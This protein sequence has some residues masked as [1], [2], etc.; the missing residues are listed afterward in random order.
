MNQTMK[1]V[2]AEKFYEPGLVS[3]DQWPT[4]S[5]FDL[6]LQRP[7]TFRHQNEE[8]CIS[9]AEQRGE[10][11]MRQAALRPVIERRPR[12]GQFVKRADQDQIRI[13]LQ[14][15]ARDQK[16][17]DALYQHE[18]AQQREIAAKRRQFFAD[19]QRGKSAGGKKCEGDAEENIVNGGDG[20]Q[21]PII[22]FSRWLHAISL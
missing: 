5:A 2:L 20:E 16:I 14:I 17:S 21:T 7:I 8:H 3:D 22:L 19:A 12:I 1:T 11:N 13:P 6:F 4:I 9:H 18:Q 15:T 10:G